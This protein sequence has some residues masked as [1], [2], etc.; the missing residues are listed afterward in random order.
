VVF[1][2]GEAVTMATDYVLAMVAFAATGVAALLG[3]TSHG[4]APLLS[5]ETLRLIWRLTYASVGVANLCILYGAAVS[6]FGPI[7]RRVALS[8]LVLRLLIVVRALVAWGDFRYVLY[9]YAL[10][11]LA[12][13]AFA[14]WLIPRRAR[15][16]G[17][18]LAGVA[19]SLAGAL[20][21]NG[22]WGAGRAFN[23]NDW[24]HLIQALGLVLYA[25]AGRAAGRRG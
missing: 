18:L 6:V 11:L 13:A 2:P 19:V 21:Q 9:D 14:G 7:G 4:Y 16:G 3:G 23:H 15:G 8:V 20:V 5:R 22:R 24:F 12:L 10:T 1:P 17:W 25:H